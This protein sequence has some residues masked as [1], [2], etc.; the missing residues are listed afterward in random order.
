MR[1]ITTILTDLGASP[2]HQVHRG[3]GDRTDLRDDI[4]ILIDS[5]SS[6]QFSQLR[7]A[8]ALHFGGLNFMKFHWMASSCLFNRGGTFS[9]TVTNNVL[10][11][12]FQKM[13]TVQF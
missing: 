4:L 1:H 9:Q 2:S 5:R 7:G 6:L 13:R 11:A 8:A 12:T 10:F 3:L